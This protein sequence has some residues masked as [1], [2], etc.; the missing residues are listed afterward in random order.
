MFFYLHFHASFPILVPVAGL[1]VVILVQVMVLVGI[2]AG[3][4]L[5][6]VHR[7]LEAR[8]GAEQEAEG[9]HGPAAAAAASPSRP[10]NGVGGLVAVVTRRQVVGREVG[11]GAH[12][13]HP[14]GFTLP[15]LLA[16]K[17]NSDRIPHKVATPALTKSNTR[18][19][20]P[21]PLI[22]RKLPPPCPNIQ[23]CPNCNKPSKQQVPP[24]ACKPLNISLESQPPRNRDTESPD[25]KLNTASCETD[26]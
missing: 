5:L 15:L 4:F 1:H 7:L 22:L 17:P 12:G 8:A 9:A 16:L 26:A 11:A 13:P 25:K 20:P 24:R 2:E 19:I 6:D 14:H 18:K 21:K 10:R 23:C 3:A